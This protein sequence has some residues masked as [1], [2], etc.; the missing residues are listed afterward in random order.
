MV[1]TMAGMEGEGIAVI[2][3][4]NF[5]KVA[6]LS[7]KSMDNVTFIFLIVLFL[8]GLAFFVRQFEFYT[9]ATG[10]YR[11]MLGAI[12]E[13]NQLLRDNKVLLL[14]IREIMLDNLTPEKGD[15][16]AEDPE[17]SDRP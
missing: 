3:L 4:V 14:D 12:R 9:N 6:S 15:R 7:G 10:L 1:R 11:E 16:S 5:K 2:P 17:D 8:L 13:S